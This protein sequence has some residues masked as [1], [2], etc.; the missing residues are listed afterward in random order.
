MN[1]FSFPAHFVQK[2][3][4][5]LLGSLLVLMAMQAQPKAEVS[6]TAS[7]QE[8]FILSSNDGYGLDDCLA[9]GG[10]CG[11]VVADAW[12]EAHGLAASL[13]FGK[14]EDV[15]FSV[16]DLADTKPPSVKLPQN[17]LVITCAR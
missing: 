11:R 10:S 4:F 9:Q 12:C 7:D 15:T 14:A 3:V 1:R 5:P 2:V 17:A 8:S 16:A 13:S 6:R